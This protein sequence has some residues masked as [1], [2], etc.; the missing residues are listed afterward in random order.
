MNE[1]AKQIREITEAKIKESHLR[2]LDLIDNSA[3][4]L[5][6][7][8]SILLVLF[9]G[10][11]GV[12]YTISVKRLPL[13]T[14]LLSMGTMIFLLASIFCSLQVSKR[15]RLNIWPGNSSKKVQDEWTKV[16]WHKQKWL[17][18]AYIFIF[19]GLMLIMILGVMMTYLHWIGYFIVKQVA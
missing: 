14:C 8:C 10:T 13:I 3:C 11:A 18:L 4:N 16:K 7:A 1:I 5:L 17:R 19:T 15:V 9:T 6:Q 2:E 12:L